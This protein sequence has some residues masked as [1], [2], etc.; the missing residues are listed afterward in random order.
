[1]YQFLVRQVVPPDPVTHMTPETIEVENRRVII[2]A[3]ST[4]A[5]TD[6]S[7][8][9]ERNGLLAVGC[10]LMEAVKVVDRGARDEILISVVSSSFSS[11]SSSSPSPLPSPHYLRT[12]P[13]M[14]IQFGWLKVRFSL[15]GCRLSWVCFEVHSAFEVVFQRPEVETPIYWWKGY[16]LMVGIMVCFW[17]DGRGI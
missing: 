11:L 3:A 14:L 10:V 5:A 12:L 6:G 1:M 4:A 9:G 7:G 16:G 15:C 2:I 13:L 17:V 8:F